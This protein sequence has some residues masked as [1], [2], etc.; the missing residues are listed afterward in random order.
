MN[1]E[2]EGAILKKIRTAREKG[3]TSVND[4]L[5]E[6]PYIIVSIY[7]KEHKD[8]KDVYFYKKN[9]DYYMKQP[10][11]YIGGN[12]SE[13]LYDMLNDYEGKAYAIDENKIY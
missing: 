6:N 1:D 9:G 10:Y 12:I 13:E 3:K 4:N 5:Q 7:T 11:T 8:D 2:D